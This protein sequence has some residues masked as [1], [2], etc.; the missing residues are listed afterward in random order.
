[1]TAGSGDAVRGDLGASRRWTSAIGRWRHS[2]VIISTLVR[3][4]AAFLGFLCAVG[5][6]TLAI[7]K[8]I[9]PGPL[10][11]W[12]VV[13]TAGAWVFTHLA[14]PWLASRIGLRVAVV[15]LAGMHLMLLA[16]YLAIHP[17]IDTDGFRLGGRE[18]GSSDSDDALEVALAELQEGRFPYHVRTFLGNPITPLPG[19]L[20]FAAPFYFAGD[21]G[22][23]N[24]LW[25]GLLFGG[26]AWYF[27]APAMACVLAAGTFVLCPNLLYHV[28][29]GTDYI[30]NGIYVLTFSALLLEAIRWRA[31]TWVEVLASAILG[32]ALSSRLNFLVTTPLLFLAL[33]ELR[34]SRRAA[35]AVVPCVLA[36]L[37][38]TLPFYLRDPAGFSPLHTLGKLSM[39][40]SMPW[41]PILVP[42]LGTLLAFALGSRSGSSQLQRWLCNSFIVQLCLV[43]SGMVLATL[44]GG[45]PGI[46]YAHFALLA[47]PFGVASFG[48]SLLGCA[49]PLPDQHNRAG[50][51]T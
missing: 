50:A 10:L 45:M 49:L 13:V 5:Y 6:P 30:S 15:G 39:G 24:V 7:L 2:V 18:F 43:A 9:G 42:V 44:E 36:F 34:G 17:A 23:Q 20:L 12:I 3:R 35:L 11:A 4:N 27:R 8:K 1:M 40:G 41:A 38:V 46:S 51:R 33:R 31:A 16:G 26:I 14:G 25:L 48:P 29:Q 32:I 37:A 19:A 28:L 21:V 22:L 47:L